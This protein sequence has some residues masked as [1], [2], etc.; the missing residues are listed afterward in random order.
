MDTLIEFYKGLDALNLII[1]WGIIVVIILLLIFAIVISNKNKKLKQIIASR[2]YQEPSLEDDLPINV[3]PNKSNSNTNDIL[4]EEKSSIIK[5]EQKKEITFIQEKAQEN[6]PHINE[7]KPIAPLP[8]PIPEEKHFVAEEHVIEYENK[9][10]KEAPIKKEVTSSTIT[11][12]NTPY[13]RNVLRE[14]SLGQTSPIGIVKPQKKEIIQAKELNKNLS[15]AQEIS[16]IPSRNDNSSRHSSQEPVQKELLTKEPAREN[17]ITKENTSQVNIKEPVYSSLLSQV[18]TV[19]KKDLSSTKSYSDNPSHLNIERNNHENINNPKTVSSLKE[20]HLTSTNDI[21]REYADVPK[22][23]PKSSE[24]ETY[25]EEVSQK[26]SAAE[27]DD[28]I[29]R[30][31]YELQQEED[32]IISYEE[33]M[34]KKDSIKIVDEEDAVISIDEL[35]KKKEA[36]EKLYNLTPEEENDKFIKELKDF[37]NDL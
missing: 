17:I 29:H 6:T 36:E 2:N 23:K 12:P 32:A 11:I 3:T 21:F 31:A 26:L 9:F 1:F 13:Q 27:N 33:L 8:K 34:Q 7:E 20:A 15:E 4:T 16:S 28:N 35:I 19:E 14:M 18:S 5:E 22:Q 10:P 37:R 24:K 30:T 25:L